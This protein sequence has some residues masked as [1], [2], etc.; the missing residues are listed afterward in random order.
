MTIMLILPFIH[1]ILNISPSTSYAFEVYNHTGH[2]VSSNTELVNSIWT[3]L[4][5][6]LFNDVSE[7]HAHADLLVHLLGHLDVAPHVPDPVAGQQHELGLVVDRV[8]VHYRV[9]DHK[10]LLARQVF[11]RFLVEVADGAG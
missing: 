11:V 1:Q 3:H 7:L 4:M 6:H 5:E 10:L 9:H 2:V 8:F